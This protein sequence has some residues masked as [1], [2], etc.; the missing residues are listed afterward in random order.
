MHFEQEINYSGRRREFQLCLAAII[1]GGGAARRHADVTGCHC[2]RARTAAAGDGWD[3][4]RG[5]SGDASAKSL[6]SAP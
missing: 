1:A 4:G 5:P 6:S 2:Q 3:V